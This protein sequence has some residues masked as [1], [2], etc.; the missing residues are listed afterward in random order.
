[1]LPLRVDPDQFDPHR[2]PR[3]Q[4]VSLDIDRHCVELLENVIMQDWFTRQ[5]DF[6]ALVFVRSG[7]ESFSNW[8]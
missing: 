8:A 4:V 6:S 3:V 7:K 5:A 2:A 1:M